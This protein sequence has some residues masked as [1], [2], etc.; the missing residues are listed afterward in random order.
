MAP[1]SLVSILP[2]YSGV[3][4]RERNGCHAPLLSDYSSMNKC[5]LA[6]ECNVALERYHIYVHY[7]F[8]AGLGQ[9]QC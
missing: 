9:V 7:G 4:T 6:R 3:N 8:S 2:V 5:L 1:I